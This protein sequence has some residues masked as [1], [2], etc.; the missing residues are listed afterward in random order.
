MSATRHLASGFLAAALVACCNQAA[1]QQGWYGGISVGLSKLAIDDSSIA[2]PPPAVPNVS[3]DE[4]D[5]GYKFF[6]GYRFN[7]HLAA[8]GGWTD[9]G[10]FTA[11]NTVTAPTPGS[12]T[13][14]IKVSGFHVEG[15]AIAPLGDFSLFA[16]AGGMYSM[17]RTS[18]NGSGAVGVVG[19]PNRSESEFNFKWGFGG[20]YDVARSVAVRLEYEQVGDVGDKKTTGEGDVRMI[21]LGLI[22]KF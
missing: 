18:L 2:V 1:A 10:K 22:Y 16:K 19:N 12:A 3:K 11:T 8:E 4:T 13:T 7:E 5:I 14:Q 20:A 21:S 6:A 17:T 9:F 15:L